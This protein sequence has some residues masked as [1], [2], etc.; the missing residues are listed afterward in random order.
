MLMPKRMVVWLLE[1]SCEALLLSLFL[2]VL[3]GYDQHAFG[4]A[5]LAFANGV[6]LLFFTT[7]YLLTT[8]IVRAVWR[9]QRLWLYPVIATVVFLIHFE[10]LNVGI[11]GAFEPPERLRIRLAGACVLFACTF[12]GGWILRKWVQQAAS[13]SLQATN[14]Q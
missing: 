2:I 6:A 13:C 11:G 9:S 1:T 5:L 8:A 14:P 4:R 7:G 12:A 3:Y 10:I